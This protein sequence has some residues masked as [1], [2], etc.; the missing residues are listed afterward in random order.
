[1]MRFVKKM[2]GGRKAPAARGR[3]RTT[4]RLTVEGLEERS[5]MTAGLGLSLNSASVLGAV[6]QPVLSSTPA[7]VNQ[8]APAA[9]LPSSVPTNPVAYTPDTVFK[10]GN[11]WIDVPASY[12]PTHQTPTEL[13]VW[14]HGCGGQSK[15]DIYNVA[16][17]AGGPTYIT[18][19]IDGRE[20][21]CWN[22]NTDPARVLAAIADVKT[23]FNINPQRVVLGGYSSGGDLSYRVA[24]TNSTQIAG[25]LA[26]NTSP[27][28]DTGLSQD[29]ALAAP[30]HFHIVHLAHLED[31]TY[32]IAGVRAETDAVQAAGLPGDGWASLLRIEQHGS[33]WDNDNGDFGTVHDLQTYLLPHLGDGWTSQLVNG[34]PIL[35][36]AA[37]AADPTLGGTNT[38]LTVQATDAAGGSNVTFH[39]A[40]LNGPA[41]VTFDANDSAT[42]NT[43]HVTFAQAGNYTLQ[44]TVSDAAGNTITSSVTVNVVQTLSSIVLSPGSA[45]VSP[46]GNQQFTAQALDQFGNA[47]AVQP[48]F[49]WSVVNGGGTIDATGL[50]QAPMAAG[51][52]TVNVASGA[53]SGTA[54][55]TITSVS[56]S[57]SLVHAFDW[58][59]GFTG[60]LT[61]TNTG[62]TAINGWTLEF[63]FTGNIDA[64]QIWS[65][66]IVSHVGNHYVI[67]NA[68]W[69]ATIAPGKSITFRFNADY[70]ADHT[71]PSNYLL[72]GNPIAQI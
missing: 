8:P 16:A 35:V 39:W 70:G 28:R 31:D 15:Y 66:Q 7:I 67:Q 46:N 36:Q 44:A 5:L 69:D 41:P 3:Q 54:A 64:S 65:A 71:E 38:T 33:H 26:E 14:S 30:F 27:F 58:G 32:P 56:A 45:S 17:M 59:T 49:T 10:L 12:D 13:F 50:Y 19:A 43:T 6:S 68:A 72:N 40:A 9:A 53:V 57:V 42:A 62:N 4:V 23:H 25:V 48:A 2:F 1:M 11:Y 52:A 60:D 63:D 55:V 18:I 21:G 34:G 22:M 37:Q 61:L 20:G 29:Q 24:F 47:L 51:S